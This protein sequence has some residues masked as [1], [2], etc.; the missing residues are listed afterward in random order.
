MTPCSCQ[1]GLVD[2]D[3]CPFG[4]PRQHLVLE[5][6]TGSSAGWVDDLDLDAVAR[7]PVGR[8]QR[9]VVDVADGDDRDVGPLAADRGATE[10]NS[11]IA[12]V[13]KVIA[14]SSGVHHAS[15]IAQLPV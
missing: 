12:T 6:G 5:A 14:A 7:E 4:D 3:A 8:L 9:E 11:T 1:R 13:S 15:D 2:D 10:G